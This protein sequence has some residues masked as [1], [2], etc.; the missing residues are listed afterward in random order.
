MLFGGN[1]IKQPA[2]IN[3]NHRIVSELINTD[4]IMNSAF[5]IGVYP[6]LTEKMMDYVINKFEK[7][8][9]GF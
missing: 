8:I 4:Q 6:G 2:Y 3:R 1:L 7:F 5:W 9:G